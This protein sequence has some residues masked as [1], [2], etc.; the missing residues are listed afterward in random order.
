MKHKKMVGSLF[1]D[2][3]VYSYRQ[4]KK[5]TMLKSRVLQIKEAITPFIFF[6]L[7]LLVLRQ[8]FEYL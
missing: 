1:N 7:L 6:H 2:I 4:L 5:N 3:P 8:T